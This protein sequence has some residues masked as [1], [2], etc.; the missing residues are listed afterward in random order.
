MLLMV[1]GQHTEV[2]IAQMRRS[3][4]TDRHVALKKMA[5]DRDSNKGQKAG[6]RGHLLNLFSCGLLFADLLLS[7]RFDCFTLRFLSGICRSGN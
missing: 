7:Q 1:I 2:K 3:L 5:W 6:K 4:N